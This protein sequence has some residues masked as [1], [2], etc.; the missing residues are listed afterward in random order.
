MSAGHAAPVAFDAR[1]ATAGAAAEP[2]PVVETRDRWAGLAAWR[3][4]SGRR[5]LLLLAA[6]FVVTRLLAG[7]VAAHPAAYGDPEVDPGHDVVLYE[8]YAHAMV[9]DRKVPYADVDIEYPPGALAAL[10]VPYLL[11]GPAG[12]GYRTAFIATMVLVDALGA[13]ALVSLGRRT[14]WWQGLVAWVLVVPL[15]G[16]VV[17][18]RFDLLPAVLTLWSVERLAADRWRG[19]GA[20]LGAAVAVK[21]YAVF[22]LP[23]VLVVARRRVQVLA[24]ALVAMAVVTLPVA[25]HLGALAHDLQA[26]Q[27]ARGLHWESTWGSVVMVARSFGYHA[28]VVTEYG[29]V[30]IVSTVSRGF[31]LAAGLVSVA[32]VVATARR[33]REVVRRGSAPALALSMFGT[34]ALL[35]G[36]GYVYSPQYV[37]WALALGAGAL[38]LT[39]ARAL[40]PF[41]VLAVVTVLSHL[42]YPVLWRGLEGGAVASLSALVARNALTIVAGALALR[43]LPGA[44]EDAAP[45]PVAPA[46]VGA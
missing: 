27:G 19:A 18:T 9:T 1:S 33:C 17:Y 5:L 14:G 8:G 21:V 23:Q 29:A 16:P 28:V 20:L 34:M 24:A 4:R 26:T 41:A 39:P 11:A 12:V 36:A 35:V 42:V 2:R 25:A 30:D 45:T 13:M 6:A 3:P 38:A 32:I 46:E 15:L 40:R 37:L 7:L 10:D 44:D 31:R 43:A 22:L